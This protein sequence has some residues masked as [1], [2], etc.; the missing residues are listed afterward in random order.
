MTYPMSMLQIPLLK[1]LCS[2]VDSEGRNQPLFCE[3]ID[4]RKNDD[5]IPIT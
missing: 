4:H 1:T 2:Q 5:A 3:I